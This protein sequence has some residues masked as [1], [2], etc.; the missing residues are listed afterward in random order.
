MSRFNVTVHA[1][2]GHRSP[3]GVYAHNATSYEITA[4]G[5]AAYVR[6]LPSD[7]AGKILLEYPR[8]F[9][10]SAEVA[11]CHR[12]LGLYYL[13]MQALALSGGPVFSFDRTPDADAAWASWLG[14]ELAPATLCAF[15]PVRGP[16]VLRQYP[17]G[18]RLH[19]LN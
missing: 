3:V 8:R 7:F 16:V 10:D 2:R 13:A 6:A 9:V 5:R 18:T 12:R 15:D 4:Y 11:P 14:L 19:K 1:T 17:A